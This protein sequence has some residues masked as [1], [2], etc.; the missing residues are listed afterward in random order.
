MKI[1]HI[2]NNLK[3][4]SGG[5]TRVALDMTKNL[6]KLGHDVYLYT[7]ML[8]DDGVSKSKYL[9]EINA[10]NVKIK[11][12]KT[13]KFLKYPI[14]LR[15]ILNTLNN[16]S[17]FDIVH[18][19][20][21]YT[22]HTPIIS[23][24][25]R[26]FKKPYIIQTHGALNPIIRE[27]SKLIKIIFHKLFLDKAI[28]KASAVCYTA[29]E[30]LKQGHDKLKYSSKPIIIPLGIN[31]E[32]FQFYQEG[33]FRKKYPQLNNNYYILFLGR[34][35]YIKGVELL[36]KAFVQLSIDHPDVWLVIVGPENKAYS[37]YIRNILQQNE[38]INKTIFTGILTGTEKLSAY[39]DSDVFVLP[40][41]SENF[42]LTIPEAFAFNIPVIT[43]NKVNIWR[44]L[45]ENNA[46]IIINNNSDELLSSLKFLIKNSELKEF[47]GKNGNRL[48]KEKYNWEIISKQLVKEYKEIIENN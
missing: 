11:F 39:K 31:L 36:A 4:S 15:L 41:Y 13:I 22:F 40:S 5:P 35:E 30:E 20:E 19:H 21:L 38:A 47:L 29:E 46:A 7:T 48:V 37:N 23:L 43:T 27:K 3:I 28:N 26:I 18:I 32:E 25:C 6:A 9:N 33:K 10:Q 14:P 42:G 34:V 12:F 17:N 44:D 45:E 16:I 2:I 8:Y 1:L 24:I